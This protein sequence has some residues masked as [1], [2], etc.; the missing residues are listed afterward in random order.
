VTR[1]AAFEEALGRAQAG[2]WAAAKETYT[3]A[4]GEAESPEAR[5]GL[6]R[7]CWWLGEIRAAV[8]HAERAFGAYQK[9]KRYDA[10]AML[11]LHLCLWYMTNLDNVAAA[12]G[13]LSRARHLAVRSGGA[14]V[15][16]WSDL[17]SG[18]LAEDPD[19]GRRL[20]E[21]AAAAAE[22]ASDED[23][24]TMALAD[25]GLWHVTTGNVERGMTM[26][27]EAM[28]AT[29]AGPRRMLEVVVWSSCNMLAAC[30][31][32]DDLR[33]ATEWCRAAD[34]F[35]D[36]YGC[37]FLQAR[38]RAHY[39]RVLMATGRWAEAE[40]ELHH[41]LAMAEDTG[42][43]PRTESLTALA[44]LRLRQGEPDAALQLLEDADRTTRGTVTQAD[45]LVATGR[46]EEAR[47]VLHGEL[48][49]QDHHD[50]TYPAVVAALVDADLATGHV[51]EASR[52]VAGDAPAWQAP[53]YPH[54]AG[55]L[56]R[57]AGR[58]ALARGDATG[59]HR[60][61]GFALDVF[62][63]LELPFEAAV[64][65]LDLAR[66]LM[67]ESA[68]AAIA[69]STYALNR[70]RALGASREADMAAAMLRSLGVTPA[71][72]RRTTEE[73]SVREREVLALL[74]EGL[75]NPDIAGRLY[76]SPRTVGHHVSSILRKLGLRSRAEAAA[77]AARVDNRKR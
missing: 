35:T 45:C 27:D 8:A 62:A 64:T 49:V 3:A 6:A 12:H 67:P 18:Y 66:L 47:T 71:P 22:A 31:L 16:G 55:L 10:G 33:R 54:A 58:V 28:A 9:D 23:L 48:A 11:G 29:L 7:A 13:W 4:L 43:G 57:A 53:A 56:A 51:E 61:L 34:R 76:L 36:T 59:A 42:R 72:G 32:L 50:P 69:R 26:L 30:S 75:S 40:V 24:A 46:P 25:L 63:R 41:A 77:Y 5:E 60:Q 14:V 70:L 19:D 44:E 37:P 38:C 15:V 20:I 39:G 73:L 2:D 52:V 17:I 65:E 68:E 74:A 21:K 1:T